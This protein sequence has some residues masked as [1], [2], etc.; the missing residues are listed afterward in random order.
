MP[1]TA[2]SPA[3]SQAREPD[4]ARLLAA[5]RDQWPR[6]EV[7]PGKLGRSAACATPSWLSARTAAAV[8]VMVCAAACSLAP[9]TCD[10]WVDLRSTPRLDAL[11]WL[12]SG[13]ADSSLIEASVAVNAVGG[14]PLSS[15][16]LTAVIGVAW[17][18]YAASVF[19]QAPASTRKR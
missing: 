9:I 12:A 3:A 16:L 6:R 18:A 7:R 17:L 15:E 1:G 2:A 11:T 19:R 5:D 14:V 4:Q 13:G 10:P 8:A